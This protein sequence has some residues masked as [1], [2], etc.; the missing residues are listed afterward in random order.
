MKKIL[1]TLFLF[2]S[3]SVA[4]SQSVT[5]SGVVTSETGEPLT[6]VSVKVKNTSQGTVTDAGGRFELE[7]P[8]ANET[9]IFSFVGFK[10]RE[11]PLNGQ[12]TLNVILEEDI[13]VLDGVVVQGFRDFKG[14]ARKRLE[15]IQSIPESISAIDAAQIEATGVVNTGSF[16]NQIPGVTYG[17]SQDPGTVLINIRGI[18]QIRYG[19]SP[20]AMIVDGVYLSSPDLNVQA[21][22]D[23]EQIEVIKGAQGLF[24]GK[25]AI[26]G[27][28]VITT[29]PFTDQF[30]GKV[31]AG[32]GN[33][34]SY[35]GGVQL[36]GPLKEEKIYYRLSANYANY[37]GLIN[38]PT[39]DKFVDYK[40][41]LTLRGT[42]NFEFAPQTSL[43]LTGEYGD[44]ESGA[45]TFVSSALNDDF[46]SLLGP[47]PNAG[48]PNTYKGSPKGDFLGTGTLDKVLTS[49]NFE[50]NL[51][52]NMRL[53]AIL[54]YV[55]V[56]LF[57][58]GDYLFGAAG[59]DNYGPQPLTTQDMVRESSTVNGEFRLSSVK[60]GK[61]RWSAGT[62][63]QSIKGIWDT[64]Q[65]L[66]NDVTDLTYA[67][68]TRIP[69]TNDENQLRSI[70][71]FAFLN[72]DITDKLT[73]S[74][75]ARNEFETIENTE[76]RSEAKADTSYS[77]FQPK[78]SVS[79][80]F[81]KDIMA[82]ASYSGGFRSGGFNAAAVAG[83]FE[84]RIKP[85]TTQS[86]ELGIK[87]SFWNNRVIFNAAAFYTIYNNQQV[88]RF[89]NADL[90]GD[91]MATE[92]VL[93]TYNLAESTAR[94]IEF[95]TRI[96]LNK[97]LD[98]LGGFSAIDTEITEGGVVAGA[99]QEDS[100][101]NKIPFAPQSSW[102]LGLFS[103][104]KMND[105]VTWSGNVMLENKGKKY[106]FS[107]NLYGVPQSDVF[108]D[109]YTLVNA[110]IAAEFSDFTVG[111]WSNNLFDTQYNIEYW[112]FSAFGAG[113]IRTPSRPRTF[114]LDLSYRF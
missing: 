17:E 16:L 47:N 60:E 48:S 26:G 24:Y 54:S 7:P 59:V 74:A 88:Y 87:T 33:G 79:Y 10:T 103:Q 52:D 12:T 25:N 57:Y 78:A 101:G 36:S 5:V 32:Y 55:D 99:D 1:P 68:T 8:S 15:S 49:A 9:L 76:K 93:G 111:I 107:D 42:L 69:L 102:T 70:G 51:S 85:E 108:Q 106:W 56:K 18:P 35:L 43:S 112:P 86:T 20:V 89:G 75:G 31:K 81:T 22:Y 23:I 2:C 30:E 41:D 53:N 58:D 71:I 94:G 90:N 82:Y 28:V 37:D 65:Y 4:I 92:V 97:F 80:A 29:K 21:L 11:V 34:N 67:N 44:A 6:G 14:R 105:Q 40:R 19:P 96:R 38:N 66:N 45:I 100:E 64:N 27:A 3:T 72:Y 62:F 39:I 50:T 77:A 91:G 73:L 104:V 83:Q 113:D 98:L 95:D 61:F 13:S 84:K 63:L 46:P 109:P 110:R 114:G